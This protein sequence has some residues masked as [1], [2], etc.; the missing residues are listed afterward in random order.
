MRGRK[1]IWPKP[2]RLGCLPSLYLVHPSLRLPSLDPHPSALVL[3]PGLGYPCGP[4]IFIWWRKTV[5]NALRPP[6]SGEL[7]PPLALSE[8][9]ALGGCLISREAEI[10]AG[11]R[12]RCAAGKRDSLSREGP[13]C[14]RAAL[15]G[16]LIRFEP[17]PKPRVGFHFTLLLKLI[18]KT[19]TFFAGGIQGL[20]RP[21]VWGGEMM[22]SDRD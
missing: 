3:C 22:D 16:A 4:T 19:C 11:A 8:G 13:R 17:Y 15:R 1:Q 14:C 12:R 20:A 2:D 21:P 10:A 18:Q 9:V 6:G 5:N 7:T